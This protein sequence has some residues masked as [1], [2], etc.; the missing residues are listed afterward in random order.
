MRAVAKFQA[1]APAIQRAGDVVMPG[2]NDKASHD[3]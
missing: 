2:S 1:N 3:Y